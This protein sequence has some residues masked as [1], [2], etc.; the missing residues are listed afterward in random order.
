MRK[1]RDGTLRP[2]LKVN[3]CPVAVLGDSLF[4]RSRFL[5][6]SFDPKG[7]EIGGFPLIEVVLDKL[8]DT[9]P[10]RTPAETGA[11]LGEILPGPGGHDLHIAVFGI[12]HP[13]A[14]IQFAGLAMNEPAK[15][16]P[17]HASANEKMQHHRGQSCRGRHARATS[18]PDTRDSPHTQNHFRASFRADSRCSAT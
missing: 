16:N 17:L 3:I 15:P 5:P 11:K 18:L 8:I 6:R 7:A 2:D 1:H 14:Q 13:A 12:A 4:P 9:R 10:A